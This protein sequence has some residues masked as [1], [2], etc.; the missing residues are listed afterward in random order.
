MGIKGYFS[1]GRFSLRQVIVLLTI[2][3]LGAS[4]FAYAAITIPYTFTAGTTAKSSEVNANFQALANAMP[5]VKAVTNASTALSITPSYN[6]ILTITVTPPADGYVF[7][8]ANGTME[9][10]GYPGVNGHFVIVGITETSATAPPAGND[11]GLYLDP[12]VSGSYKFPYGAN[13]VF[14]VT[15]GVA[16]IFYLTGTYGISGST[17]ALNNKLT[18]VFIPGAIQ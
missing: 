4:V 10:S 13:A 7:L 8:T 16:K 9:V 18:A 5:A 1:K 14:P 17:N 12:S 15:G 2:V 6:D 3:A 11:S